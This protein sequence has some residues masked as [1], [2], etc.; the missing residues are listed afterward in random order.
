MLVL[1]FQRHPTRVLFQLSNPGPVAMLSFL[2]RSKKKHVWWVW[3]LSSKPSWVLCWGRVTAD[4]IRSV[5]VLFKVPCSLVCTRSFA[6]IILMKRNSWNSSTVREKEE[7]LISPCE[8]AKLTSSDRLFL[9][10]HLIPPWTRCLTKVLVGWKI[11]VILR[12]EMVVW[13]IP[14]RGIAVGKDHCRNDLH[15]WS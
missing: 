8:T 14:T 4:N 6:R 12:S 11:L 15:P 3:C 7:L 13:W 9:R 1:W 2:G 5:S 10:R